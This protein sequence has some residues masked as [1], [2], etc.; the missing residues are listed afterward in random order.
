[1]AAKRPALMATD[2]PGMIS[3]EWTFTQRPLVMSISAGARPMAT[4]TSCGAVSDQGAM[5]IFCTFGRD[6][7]LDGVGLYSSRRVEGPAAAWLRGAV[8]SGTSGHDG[9]RRAPP[10]N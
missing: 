7:G 2:V 3:P 1:M 6:G 4:S 10:K 8:L 9:E 5:G